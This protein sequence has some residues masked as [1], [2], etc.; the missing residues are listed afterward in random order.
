MKIIY[1]VDKKPEEILT[2]KKPLIFNFFNMHSLYLFNNNSQFRKSLSNE[3][4]VNF[5]DGK[6]ISIKLGV[7]QK[8]GPTFTK[9]FLLSGNSKLKKHFFIGNVNKKKLS[10]ITD[11]PRKN[12]YS[13]DLPFIKELEFPKR[14][15][16]SILKKL[17]SFKPDFVWVCI[18]NPKQEILSNYLY[19]KYPTNYFNVGA[20][21]DFLLG[22]KSESPR[23]FRKICLEWFYRGLTDF[24]HSKIKIWRSILAILYLNKIYLK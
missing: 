16:Y 15:K 24:K 9:H 17:K 14:E 4:S 8:R 3:N 21:M 5:P 1:F 19:T 7:S 13:Y 12:I 10:K 22:K 6:L 18:G 11:I 2:L 20:G 23:F